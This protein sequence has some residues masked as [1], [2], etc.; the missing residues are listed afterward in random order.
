MAKPLPLQVVCEDFLKDNPHLYAH[1]AKRKKIALIA[2]EALSSSDSGTVTIDLGAAELTADE[3]RYTVEPPKRIIRRFTKFTWDFLLFLVLD[4]QPLVCLID[5]L[6]LLVGPLYK[7]RLRRQLRLLADGEMT[8]RAGERK[9]ALLGFRGVCGAA[10][11]VQLT[12]RYP[13][14]RSEQVECPIGS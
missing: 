7:R 5:L 9:K 4:F 12:V 14:G 11:Q 10:T 8:L 3:K 1:K 6:C 13:D 2:I